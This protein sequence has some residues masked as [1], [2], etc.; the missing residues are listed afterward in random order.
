MGRASIHQAFIPDVLGLHGSARREITAE[1]VRFAHDKRRMGAGWG[2]IAKMLGCS[3]PDIRAVADPSYASPTPRNVSPSQAAAPPQ[4]QGRKPKA[5]RPDGAIPQLS[6]AE[7]LARVRSELERIHGTASVAAMGSAE[8]LARGARTVT[9][10]AK[11]VGTSAANAGIRLCNLEKDGLVRR[12]RNPDGP[13]Y[14]WWLGEP[15][16]DGQ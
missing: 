15:K 11:Y 7:K 14:V 16:G 13:G 5:A 1:D 9:E 3:E 12:R 10:V 4:T 8:A 6:A 2:G